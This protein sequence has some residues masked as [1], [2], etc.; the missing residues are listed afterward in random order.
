SLGISPQI[1][2]NGRKVARLYVQQIPQIP[3]PFR[4]W[5]FRIFN[6]TQ[7]KRGWILTQFGSSE[8]ILRLYGDTDIF[9]DEDLAYCIAKILKMAFWVTTSID[10]HNKSTTASHHFI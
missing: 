2:W 4:I 9:V 6:L 1:G 3:I 10:N 7:R 5:L 8:D